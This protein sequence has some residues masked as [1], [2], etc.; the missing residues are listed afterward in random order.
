MWA[1]LLARAGGPAAGAVTADPDL[2]LVIDG[3]RLESESSAGGVHRFVVPRRP[4]ARLLL[5]S[6]VGVPSLLGQGRSNHRP[7]GVA[8][9]QLILEQAGI[10]TYLDYDQP[11]LREAGCYRHEDG[12]AWTDGDLQ[13]PARFLPPLARPFTLVVRTEPHPDMRYPLAPMSAMALP[14]SLDHAPPVG[15]RPKLTARTPPA[16][17]AR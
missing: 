15:A 4:V 16:R 3:E 6:R 5:R 2:H 8:I 14:A 9:T 13:L 1:R 11:Q 10:A 12:F 17:K 7:L